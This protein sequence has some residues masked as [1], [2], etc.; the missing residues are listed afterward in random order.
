MFKNTQSILSKISKKTLAFTVSTLM[1]NMVIA[2]ASATFTAVDYLETG[3]G[4]YLT[5]K[6]KV[7]NF[8]PSQNKNTV[9]ENAD[10][11]LTQ[12]ILYP[13][14]IIVETRQR[15]ISAYNAGDI[16][17]CDGSPCISANGENICEALKQG[18]KRCAANFVPFGTVL[19]IEGYGQCLVTD[20][21]NSRYTSRVD[22]AMPLSAKQEAREFGLQ[23]LE[24]KILAKL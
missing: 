4:Q 18:F 20:R 17:Q 23:T 9:L 10:D 8:L 3:Y 21:M 1:F 13:E 2:P 24:V 11:L 15:Q 6:E 16:Y 7:D 12:R 14:Q 22:I 19:D 5:N